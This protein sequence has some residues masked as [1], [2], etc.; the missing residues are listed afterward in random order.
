MPTLQSVEQTIITEYG[1]IVGTIKNYAV[2][3]TLFAL[4]LGWAIGHYL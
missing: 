3:C 2:P 4:V 1:V